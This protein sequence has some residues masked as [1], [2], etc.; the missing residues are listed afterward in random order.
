MSS[1]ADE[2]VFDI[3]TTGGATGL[4]FDEF[5]L[6]FLGKQE[7]GRA[8]EIKFNDGTQLWDIWIPGAYEAS[9]TGFQGYDEA[10]KFEVVWLQACRKQGIEEPFSPEGNQL[11]RKLLLAWDAAMEVAG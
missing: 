1:A 6:G 9:V 4:Y 3:N 2:M 7:I 8:S 5:P 10:R 11:V